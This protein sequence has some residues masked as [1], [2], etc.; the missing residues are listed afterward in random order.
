M[1]RETLSAGTLADRDHSSL[2]K[3]KYV[4]VLEGKEAKVPGRGIR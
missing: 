2:L 4:L 1:V 3:K